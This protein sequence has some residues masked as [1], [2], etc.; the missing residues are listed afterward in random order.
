MFPQL[1]RKTIETSSS[2]E[3][4]NFHYE[5][6]KLYPVVLSSKGRE[7]GEINYLLPWKAQKKELNSLTL[8]KMQQYI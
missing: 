2:L 5:P 8:T 4:L 3:V 1:P 7:T 6:P